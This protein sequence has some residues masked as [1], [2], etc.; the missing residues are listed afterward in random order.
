MNEILNGR[1]GSQPHLAGKRRRE[2]T[3][4]IEIEG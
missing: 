3:Q 1:S 2:A 4:S